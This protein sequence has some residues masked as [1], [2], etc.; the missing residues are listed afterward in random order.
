MRVRMSQEIKT[1]WVAT[2]TADTV[3]KHWKVVE[4]PSIFA[5]L[6]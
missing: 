4:K 3:V 1:H 6:I 5:G 2:I